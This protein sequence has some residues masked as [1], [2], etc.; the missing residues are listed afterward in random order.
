MSS[1]TEE[2]KVEATEE[3]QKHL[4]VAQEHRTFY[5]ITIKK[6]NE[7][8]KSYPQVE[9]CPKTPVY[10]CSKDITLHYTFDFA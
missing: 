2:E 6:S 9:C 8:L 3:F 4:R 10:Q 1:F 7:A 5:S